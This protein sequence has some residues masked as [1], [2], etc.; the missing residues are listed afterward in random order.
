MAVKVLSNVTGTL[1]FSIVAAA[2]PPPAA[3][4]DPPPLGHNGGPPLDEEPKEPV[5]TGGDYEEP[6]FG[7]MIREIR[8][9][10]GLSQ[11]EL[12]DLSGVSRGALRKIESDERDGHIRTIARL[13]RVVGY[14]VDL[15]AVNPLPPKERRDRNGRRAAR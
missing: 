12:A 1:S 3:P 14:E 15:V 13:A 8:E 5:D 9:E 6:S 11:R 10:A 2:P 7:R 4:S